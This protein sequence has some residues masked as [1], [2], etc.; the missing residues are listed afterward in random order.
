MSKTPADTL[1]S[2]AAL[3]IRRGLDGRAFPEAVEGTAGRFHRDAPQAIRE[4]AAVV[5]FRHPDA[6][7]GQVAA[8]LAGEA[9]RIEGAR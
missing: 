2:V 1:R 7:P 6:T 9:E 3:V 5:R 8:L 4:L